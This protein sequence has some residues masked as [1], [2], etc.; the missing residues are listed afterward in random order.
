MIVLDAVLADAGLVPWVAP[1]EVLTR[2][3]IAG[4]IARV[5]RQPPGADR[6]ADLATAGEGALIGPAGPQIRLLRGP[7]DFVAAQRRL[8]SF[9]R[10]SGAVYALGSSSERV[11]LKVARVLSVG[12]IRLANA[13]AVAVAKHPGEQ[14]LVEQF[15]ARIP[16][17]QALH[18]S[19]ARLVEFER[20]SSPLALAQQS[21]MV[22]QLRVFGALPMRKPSLIA[23]NE[24]TH[25]VAVNLGKA[26]RREGLQHK[27]IRSLQS[28]GEDLPVPRLMADSRDPFNVACRTLANDLAPGPRYE[29]RA[30]SL[31]REALRTALERVRMG[32]TNRV[33]GMPNSRQRKPS[34]SLGLAADRP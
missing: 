2:R 22:T 26:L 8:A 32:A 21:E 4:D 30:P 28:R 34:Q 33:K 25:E 6:T 17:Y 14:D 11:G 23:L 1:V 19:T 20:R 10:A 24:A 18:A 7:E 12:Q 9:V 13:F 15:R 16:A 31:E 5:T 27:N 3:L 29:R